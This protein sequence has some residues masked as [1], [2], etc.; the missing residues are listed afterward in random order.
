MAVPNLDT[1]DAPDANVTVPVNHRCHLPALLRRARDE[2][3]LT[4]E[5]IARETKIPEHR[6]AALEAEA[7]ESSPLGFYERAQIRA[8]A[9]AVKLDDQVVQTELERDVP[10][11]PVARLPVVDSSQTASRRHLLM[12]ASMALLAVAATVWAS[13]R[14]HETRNQQTMRTERVAQIPF[15]RP[16]QLEGTIDRESRRDSAP[17]RSERSPETRQVHATRQ[18]SSTAGAEPLNVPAAESQP[19]AL[20]PSRSSPTELTINSQPAGARVTVNGVGWGATPLTI[21]YLSAGE[22][23]IRVTKDGYAASERMVQVYADR[24]SDLQVQLAPIP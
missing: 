23:R 24:S 21:R 13:A 22:K 17:A 19:V 2:Q 15:D 10:R 5:Q 12:L 8:F 9:R 20:P 14:N 4:L 1:S 3:R 11:P 7:S 18:V 6:L 16:E